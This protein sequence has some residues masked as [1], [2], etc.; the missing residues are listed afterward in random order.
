MRNRIVGS[1]PFSRSILPADGSHMQCGMAILQQINR[2]GFAHLLAGGRKRLGKIWRQFT[3]PAMDENPEQMLHR[4]LL[5]NF[6]LYR[7]LLGTLYQLMRHR[8][9]LPL[10]CAQ[11]MEDFLNLD[12]IK[13]GARC[14]LLPDRSA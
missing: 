14:E 12:G 4:L 13:H 1:I 3:L 7:Q 9:S 8:R 2:L 6:P 11:P 5:G 10:R